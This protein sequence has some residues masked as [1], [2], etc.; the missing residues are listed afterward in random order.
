MLNS[1]DI[2]SLFHRQFLL[3]NVSAGEV[4]SVFADSSSRPE[5]IEAAY[6]ALRL[7]GASAI[8]VTVPTFSAALFP[9]Q[10]S[11]DILAPF[12]QAIKALSSST[13]VVDI[14]RSGIVH[15]TARMQVQEAGARILTIIEPPETLARW[16]VTSVPAFD[17][18]RMIFA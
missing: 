18:T 8:V 6:S 12:P 3:C 17:V 15:S 4:A 14:T 10:I 1:T 16:K 11:A 9:N 7:I 5:Y 2:V 13:F